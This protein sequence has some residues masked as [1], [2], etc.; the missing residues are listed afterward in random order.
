MAFWMPS[1]TN[2]CD[3][4]HRSGQY[5]FLEV[6]PSFRRNKNKQRERERGNTRE[7]T[8][9][10]HDDSINSCICFCIVSRQIVYLEEKI[11]KIKQRQRNRLVAYIFFLLQ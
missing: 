6:M 8:T 11:L 10:R 4:E 2:G 5:Q 9:S 1:N 3:G 7:L